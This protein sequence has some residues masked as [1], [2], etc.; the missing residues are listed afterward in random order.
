M[1]TCVVSLQKRDLPGGT[2]WVKTF[3]QKMTMPTEF[4]VAVDLSDESS[5]SGAITLGEDS[6]LVATM[7]FSANRA[8]GFECV[9]SGRL[10]LPGVKTLWSQQQP[11]ATLVAQVNIKPTV[12]KFN[13]LLVNVADCLTNA[14]IQQANF[15]VVN[16]ELTGGF[17]VLG[18][19]KAGLL[20]TPY[21]EFTLNWDAIHWDKWQFNLI[22]IVTWLSQSASGRDSCAQRGESEVCES[23]V[24]L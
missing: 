5:W 15:E 20:D 6:A 7:T 10:Y 14:R 21:I 9:L 1:N 18:A 13:A 4:D 3:N 12:A 16:H 23:F 11:F 19:L 2:N 17:C 24:I 8:V 22:G